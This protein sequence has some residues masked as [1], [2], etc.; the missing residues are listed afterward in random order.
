MFK[1]M[2]L[3]LV[4]GF[5]F[6]AAVGCGGGGGGTT[7]SYSITKNHTTA[8]TTLSGPADDG[9]VTRAEAKAAADYSVDLS[10]Q[11][12]KVLGI[13]NVGS[14]GMGRATTAR[15]AGRS[16][17]RQAASTEY[18]SNEVDDDTGCTLNGYEKYTAQS[19]SV[20]AIESDVTWTGCDDSYMNGRYQTSGTVTEKTYDVEYYFNLVMKFT[21]VGAT[22]TV[23]MPMRGTYYPN[24]GRFVEDGLFWMSLNGQ[25]TDGYSYSNFKLQETSYNAIAVT[26][27]VSD[28][29]QFTVTFESGSELRADGSSTL[30]FHTTDGIRANFELAADGSGQCTLTQTSNGAL[31][32]SL[33]WDKSGN[34]TLTYADG[35]KESITV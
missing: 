11:L 10:R 5:A 33:V 4:C 31:L 20:V 28:N 13:E 24:T 25:D 8:G 7:S 34:G 30:K 35:T 2:L 14:A 9:V 1:R 27:A 32:G 17:A 3:M 12:Y 19:S 6:F 23:S 16:A 21:Q 29:G 18:Y 26:G 15:L 22:L